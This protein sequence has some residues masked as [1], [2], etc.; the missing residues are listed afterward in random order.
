MAPNA[1][2]AEHDR[3]PVV[4]VDVDDEVGLG[5]LAE[6]EAVPVASTI[7]GAAPG[8]GHQDDVVA[9][10]GPAARRAQDQPAVGERVALVGRAVGGPDDLPDDQPALLDRDSG[11]LRPL[12]ASTVAGREVDRQRRLACVL[13]ADAWL[14]LQALGGERVAR[15]GSVNGGCGTGVPARNRDGQRGG[16]RRGG[17]HP[18]ADQP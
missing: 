17:A 3:R 15:V 14:V 5:L 2:V 16:G 13:E 12:A 10:S 6:R 11:Q 4:F 1:A 8:V 18:V 7:L 9:R